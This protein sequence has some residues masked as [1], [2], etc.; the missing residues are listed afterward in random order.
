MPLAP[1]PF[2]LSLL[3][4]NTNIPVSSPV[5]SSTRLLINYT[6][7]ASSLRAAHTLKITFKGKEN[8]TFS[9]NGIV[10]LLDAQSTQRPDMAANS[11]HAQNHFFRREWDIKLAAATNHNSTTH[12]K[13]SPQQHTGTVPLQLP[14]HL[15]PSMRDEYRAV[16]YTLKASLRTP[17]ATYTLTRVVP[18]S[19]SLILPQPSSQSRLIAQLPRKVTRSR[20]FERGTVTCS[21]AL[22]RLLVSAGSPL[23]LH[24]NIFN[25][26]TAGI[27]HLSAALYEKYLP[28]DDEA[29][30]EAASHGDDDV[31]R[32]LAKVAFAEVQPNSELHAT[33]E[34]QVP[35]DLVESSSFPLGRMAQLIQKQYFVN[36]H[37]E[38]D[39]GAM[40]M[41]LEMP[42]FVVKEA[43]NDDE[44]ESVVASSEERPMEHREG[45]LALDHNGISTSPSPKKD[46][47]D[48]Y[49]LSTTQRNLRRSDATNRDENTAEGDELVREAESAAQEQL[50]H[51]QQAS[52][53]SPRLSTTSPQNISPQPNS[54]VSSPVTPEARQAPDSTPPPMSTTVVPSLSLPSAP[55][56]SDHG[57]NVRSP[58]PR[59]TKT[60]HNL[61]V[62]NST[63]SASQHDSYQFEPDTSA[64]TKAPPTI[65]LSQM[66]PPQLGRQSL[67]PSE[68]ASSRST[69]HSG[70]SPRHTPIGTL[71]TTP[72]M[73]DPSIHYK[74]ARDIEESVKQ[75]RERLQEYQNLFDSFGKSTNL[76][77]QQAARDNSRALTSR[78]QQQ[79]QQQYVPQSTFSNTPPRGKRANL[80]PSRGAAPTMHN[81]QVVNVQPPQNSHSKVS[82][83]ALRR[84]ATQK[85]PLLSDDFEHADH[86]TSAA[87]SPNVRGALSPY[88][89]VNM[90]GSAPS[91]RMH[92]PRFSS[93]YNDTSSQDDNEIEE[94]QGP[95][96]EQRD[97]TRFLN[98]VHSPPA[99][100][101]HSARSAHTAN[102]SEHDATPPRGNTTTLVGRDH[103][104]EIRVHHHSPHSDDG[105]TPSLREQEPAATSQVPEVPVKQGSIV[106]PN[107]G[108]YVGT[109]TVDGSHRHGKGTLYYLDG[110]VYS[111]DF[112]N[113]QREGW[114][115]FSTKSY[116]YDGEF[117]NDC[118][119]G[120]GVIIYANGEQYEG[121]WRGGYPH[122]EGCYIFAD[123][124]KYVGNFERGLRNGR[125][126][127]HYSD[128]IT[129]YDGEWHNDKKQ[130]KA[131]VTFPNG[132]YVGEMQNDM[133]EGYGRYVYKNGSVF[134]G[135]WHVNQKNGK[136]SF[137]NQD[138]STYVGTWVSGAKDGVGIFTDA[139]GVQYR[140]KW[141]NGRLLAKRHAPFN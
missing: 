112:V 82:P 29:L 10:G 116:T 124:S 47:D 1:F 92:S 123:G 114:G 41:D 68:H 88:A 93:R 102:L 122:G 91:S 96:Q 31:P 70:T 118:K 30:G 4:A 107:G 23:A 7:P 24:C 58:R 105:A 76:H 11:M 85:P 62:S 129:T 90:Y 136:G 131:Q 61:T 28:V 16:T 115:V 103:D 3:H 83:A 109:I 101:G 2:H 89:D 71:T 25:G 133:K 110:S 50:N 5:A 79:P 45:L 39:D 56:D 36:L 137:K 65:N 106:Y 37:L 95:L 81:R 33:R 125:G 22:E 17:S 130:G 34:L 8:L 42:I 87:F 75:T 35:L 20:S 63:S 12:D 99:A 113:G 84:D 67:S 57:L 86:S 40:L 108:K 15:Q 111:G 134:S 53:S 64:E 72:Q 55:I 59:A 27:S 119:E 100:N 43:Q 80:T 60:H 77:V 32:G 73:M 52:Q 66:Q 120:F 140:E 127:L 97:D 98:A 48:T 138:G 126:V 9:G 69:P 94:H 117:K 6:V 135:Y 44:H 14:S 74:D 121:K 132:K 54:H 104:M 49:Q 19:G 141:K 26:S 46:H 38:A 51:Q 13:T 128:G 139:S 18:V 21:M 78:Q